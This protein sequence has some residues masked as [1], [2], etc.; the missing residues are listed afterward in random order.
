MQVAFTAELVASERFFFVSLANAVRVDTTGCIQRR[1]TSADSCST[2]RYTSIR[3]KPNGS[4]VASEN[5][6]TLAANIF[7]VQRHVTLAD[8]QCRPRIDTR[9]RTASRVPVAHS[10]RAFEA[11]LA[12]LR[13]TSLTSLLSTP[14]P[15]PPRIQRI[16]WSDQRP[17][18]ASPSG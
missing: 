15:Q 7:A 2:A 13:Q 18:P 5:R 11:L 3:P 1:P 14:R 6:S 10:R 12:E 9:K 8:R 16:E 4:L 17:P